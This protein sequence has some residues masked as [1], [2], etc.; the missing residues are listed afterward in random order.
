MCKKVLSILLV[1]ALLL[2][3]IFALPLSITAAEVN[4]EEVGTNKTQSEAVQ[5]I[6][7]RK[8]EGWAYDYDGTGG[9]AQ[10]VDLIVY[11]FEK[12]F[13]VSN[14]LMLLHLFYLY[15]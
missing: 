7:D 11:Y 3:G 9:Y 12:Q 14:L 10:C 6:T 15:S 1:T 5:W 4:S 2:S 8:N 13:L